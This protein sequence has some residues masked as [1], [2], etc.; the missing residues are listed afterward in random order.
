M[1]TKLEDWI[2]DRVDACRSYFTSVETWQ[3]RLRDAE[4]ELEKLTFAYYGAKSLFIEV[5]AALADL[6]EQSPEE[7]A[8]TTV[9]LTPVS[10]ITGVN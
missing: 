8:E 5:R 2:L 9:N 7:K 3:A 4:T 10:E 1:Y 6:D